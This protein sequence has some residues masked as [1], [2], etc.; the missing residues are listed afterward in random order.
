[1]TGL[2]W[3]Q[4]SS[5]VLCNCGKKERKK[6]ITTLCKMAATTS[7]KKMTQLKLEFKLARR[8]LFHF[9]LRI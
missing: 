1:M 9:V 3:R 2:V 8:N 4:K 6:K 7:E 5:E